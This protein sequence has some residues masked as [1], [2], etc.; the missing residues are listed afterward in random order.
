[1]NHFTLAL[2]AAL[3]LL[4]L[5]AAAQTRYAFGAALSGTN[6]V[7]PNGSP[8]RGYV[9]VVYVDNPGSTPDDLVVRGGFEGLQTNY[10]MSH[11]HE[12]PAGV[13]GPVVQG[14]TATLEGDNQSG[15][16]QEASN[17]YPAPAGFLAKLQ[18]GNIYTN[19]HSVGLSGGEIRGQLRAAP[20]VDGDLSDDQYRTLAFKLNSNAGFGPD[21]DVTRLYYYSDLQA[22]V[23]YVGVVGALNTASSDGI[24]LWLDFSELAG[25]PAGTVLGGVPNAGH[26]M[27]AQPDSSYTA[28]FE[29]D[30]AFAINPGG[31][32]SSVFFDV[33]KY[34]GTTQADYLGST[35]QSGTLAVG[36]TDDTD[37][38]GGPAFFSAVAFA[39]DNSGGAGTGLEFAIPFADLGI[40]GG[41][42]ERLS[43]FAFGV[44]SSAYFSDVTAPGNVTAGNLG[45]SPDF[46]ANLT[47]A[48]CA[49]PNP[50]TPIGVGPYH[51][52]GALGATPTFDLVAFNVTP[53]TVAAGG[54]ITF[55]YTVSNNTPNAASGQLFFTATGGSQGVIQSGTLGGNTTVGP[56]QFVQQIPAT[57]PPGTYTYT[58]KI[59]QF[60]SV[61]VDQ[62][63]FTITVT[64]APRQ[65]ASSATTEWTVTGAQPWSPE[66]SAGAGS[67]ADGVAVHPNPFT[68]RT[69][70]AFA[71]D[72]RT[73]VTLTVYDVRGREV[74]RLVDG[75]LEA[76]T[77]EA[78]FDASSLPSGVY[79]YRLTAGSTVRTGRLTVL[80]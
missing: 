73:D 20:L 69:T 70:L 78:D 74:A 8:A 61:A 42:S 51:A 7:P 59:G 25:R 30:Y 1:M 40:D 75:P 63:A 72:A 44:S 21:L 6:E 9:T 3:L 43:A 11:L 28:D 77:H 29:V 24:G 4:P 26:F 49:C 53:L 52:D 67:T 65:S 13:N 35:D 2:F 50:S 31:G 68:D 62:V 39:F 38:S 37:N 10:T 79:L 76:G 58:L 23:L 57:A 56:L 36:P 46:D 27:G 32:T 71:L 80:R 17:T 54:S 18:A 64:P 16:W 45:F 41:A 15:E 60:P 22:E 19:V 48:A 5:A 34:V 47:S 55:R 12:A 33:V 66:A 14:L